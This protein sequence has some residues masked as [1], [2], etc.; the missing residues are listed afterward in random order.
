MAYILRILN[1]ISLIRK[2][3]QSLIQIN[4]K[5]LLDNKSIKSQIKNIESNQKSNPC[6]Q[7]LI[8]DSQNNTESNIDI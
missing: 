3:E 8:S 5:S 2:H 6:N 4:I 1:T 7:I